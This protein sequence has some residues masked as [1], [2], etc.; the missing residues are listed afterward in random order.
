MLFE[1]VCFL[2]VKAG[3]H[4]SEFGCANRYGRMLWHW[5]EAIWLVFAHSGREKVELDSTSR[6]DRA[7]ASERSLF[8]LG[9]RAAHALIAH[10]LVARPNSPKW[11]PAFKPVSL[12]RLTVVRQTYPVKPQSKEE[13]HLFSLSNE[14]QWCKF[15]PDVVASRRVSF[16]RSQGLTFFTISKQVFS[17]TINAR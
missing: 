13:I 6:T 9:F 12:A 3:F 10:R 11:K 2:S 8:K 16:K 1:L 5:N 17:M 7:F 14:T 15:I 4:F